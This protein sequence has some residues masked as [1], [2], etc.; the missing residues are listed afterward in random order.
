MSARPRAAGPDAANQPPPYE[1]RNLFDCDAALRAGVAAFGAAWAEDSLRAFGAVAGGAEARAWARDANRHP[2]ELQTHDRYGERADTV[3]F[4]PAYHALMALGCEAGVHSGPWAGPRPGAQVARAATY[5]LFGQLENGTQCPLTMTFAATPVLARHADSL[6]ALA[7]DW[8]PRIHARAYDRRFL[9]VVEKRG[10]TV[11]MGMTERQ[12][13]SDVRT[14]R[15]RA[16]P[17][18][19]SGAGEAYRLDGD[20]W[21]FSAP[22]CDAFLVLAQAPGGLSCFFLPRFLP[23]GAKNGIRLLRLK[24]KLGNRSNASSEAG[25]EGATAWLI[26]DEGR[27]VPVILEMV[28]Y[29]RLDCVIGSAALMRE[30]LAQAIHHARHR[31]AFG[32]TL[33]AH[34]LMQNVLADLALESEAATML[35]LRLA[36]AYDR[37]DAGAVALRRVLTPAAKFWVCKRASAFAQE[38]MEVLG[39]NGYVEDSP[40]PRLYREA[41]VNSIWEGSGNVVCLDLLRALARER[42]GTAALEAE[43]SPARGRDAAFDAFTLRL[44]ADLP[45]AAADEARARGLAA[46]LVLAVQAALL[47]RHAPPEVAAGFCASRLAGADGRVFG[48]QDG[49]R[50]GGAI[51]A[52]AL[53]D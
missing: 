17:L 49:V 37:E 44:I 32:Q 26:G 52:R 36:Q 40:M 34:A 28:G 12:G 31:R 11:G 51:V 14:N 47:L 41:P 6:P 42:G 38:A 2:P 8:L 19:R 1:G 20:K 29:T 43:L 13:G 33:A 23:D 53:A 3:E 22:M 5:L 45:D 16:T 4:H 27:G 25:F 48:A 18:G 9:P 7:R 21:F 35:A 50:A 10:A 39:G 30:A 46:R 24:D 15:T